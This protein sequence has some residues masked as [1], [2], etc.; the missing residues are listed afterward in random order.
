MEN[1]ALPPTPH[2]AGFARTLKELAEEG[3][4]VATPPAAQAPTSAVWSP[5]CVRW[6]S[7]AAG[8]QPAFTDHYRVLL[9]GRAA[10][11]LQRVLSEAERAGL[12]YL[13]G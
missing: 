9:S 6:A 13:S 7:A 3:G 12:R 11:P 1:G 4:V 5:G 2:R 10:V 8:R